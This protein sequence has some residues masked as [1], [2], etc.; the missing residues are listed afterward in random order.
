MKRKTSNDSGLDG[1]NTQQGS[2]T[3]LH[4]NKANFKS[5]KAGSKL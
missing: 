3:N 5:P 4:A 2:Q 1:W